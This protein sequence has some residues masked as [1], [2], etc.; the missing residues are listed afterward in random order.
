[1]MPNEDLLKFK[2]LKKF[3]G[4]VTAVN[5]ISL[6]IRCD[7]VIMLVGA[8][9]AGKTTFLNIIAGLTEADDGE[10]ILSG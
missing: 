5:D 7:Q 9:G 1:M 2:N 4:K 8:N 6:K 3:Y 10:I